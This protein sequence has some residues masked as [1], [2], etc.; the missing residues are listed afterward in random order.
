M[1]TRLFDLDS[2]GDGCSDANEAYNSTNADGGDG[3]QYGLGDTLTFAEGEVDSDGK[4]VTASYATPTQTANGKYTF[5]L[6]VVLLQDKKR[7]KCY[8]NY[9]VIEEIIKP[10]P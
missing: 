8:T 6:S 10:S 3:L 1:L 9:K 2:D 4:V 5:D 7:V